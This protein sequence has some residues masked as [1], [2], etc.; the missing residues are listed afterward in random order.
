[1]I[2][3][4]VNFVWLA[5]IVPGLMQLMSAPPCLATAIKCN[6]P[7]TNVKT[8]LRGKLKVSMFVRRFITQPGHSK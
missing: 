4:V 2:Q 8:Q 6:E 7:T 5:L 3:V 1:M